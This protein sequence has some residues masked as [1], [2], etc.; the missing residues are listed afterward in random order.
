MKKSMQRILFEVISLRDPTGLHIR[1]V[2]SFGRDW[3][4]K[5]NMPRYEKDQTLLQKVTL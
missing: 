1:K 4:Y 3:H 2:M 5:I